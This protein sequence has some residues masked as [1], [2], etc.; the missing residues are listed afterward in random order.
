[1]HLLY[2]WAPVLFLSKSPRGVTHYLDT[3][4]TLCPL[5]PASI[6]VLCL[7]SHSQPRTWTAGPISP[8]IHPLV[9]SQIFPGDSEINWNTILGISLVVQWLRIQ[10]SMQETALVLEDPKCFKATKPMRYNYWARAL[11]TH[12][13]QLLKRLSQES[14]PC[15]KRSYPSE[16]PK[17]SN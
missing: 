1:M 8:A 7:G 10:L 16:K 4:D 15:N 14:R 9:Q 13:L 5:E 11:E 12:E 3:T 17:H 6:P 2:I